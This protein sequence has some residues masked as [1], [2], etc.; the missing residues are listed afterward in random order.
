MPQTSLEP[1]AESRGVTIF[2]PTSGKFSFMK[3]PFAAHTT[4]SAVDIY[5][6]GAFGDMALSPVEG[7]VI[8]IREYLTPTP[9]R[10]RDF[11]EYI[12]AVRQGD[13]V[14]KILHV[15]PAV[16]VGDT[17][18]A[19]DP[20]GTLIHNGYFYFWND[21]PLHVEVRPQENYVRASNHN[22]LKSCFE[23]SSN[24]TSP[25][26]TILC[27]VVFSDERFALLEGRYEGQQVKGYRLGGC[28]LDGLVPVA[29]VD[30]IDY[31]GLIGLHPP[32]SVIR[33][34]GNRHMVS[35]DKVKAK[36]QTNV[37]GKV[38]TRSQ[39][40]GQVDCLALGFSLSHSVPTIKVIPKRYGQKLFSVGDEVI[41]RLSIYED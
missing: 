29:Q 19:G 9:F 32:C 25:E 20:L 28:L 13:S 40:G 2:A 12:T 3:S 24:D 5:P 6:G 27:R 1:V 15:K 10:S 11:R 38:Q 17:L 39:A 22:P 34:E 31:F 26:S 37:Q 23:Y 7:T 41:I 35:T 30:D 14:V 21:P 18:S 16:K 33:S 4:L 8:D 36:V